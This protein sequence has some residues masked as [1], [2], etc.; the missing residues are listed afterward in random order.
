MGPAIEGG[1]AVGPGGP[2]ARHA[3][4]PGGGHNA[5]PPAVGQA[6]TA[7]LLSAVVA[8][9]FV[10]PV[11]IRSRL[12]LLVLAVL[13]PGMLG[14]AWMVAS[15]YEAERDAHERTLRDTARALSLL[16]DGE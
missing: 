13:L 11:S 7:K 6:G 3:G 16:V 8:F 15:T 9:H 12:L 5:A 4:C 1:S 10:M 14:V 2:R